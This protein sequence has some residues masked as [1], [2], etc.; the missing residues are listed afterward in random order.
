MI[1]KK[2]YYIIAKNDDCSQK[3]E[4]EMHTT[5]SLNG[6][7]L[8]QESPDLVVTIGGDGTFLHA[9]HSYLDKLESIKVV[10]IHTGT[11]GFF[12]N[13]HDHELDVFFDDLFNQRMKIHPIPVLQ[14]AV[15]QRDES[16]V[17]EAI[18]E[19]RVENVTRTQTLDI[20][21]NGE[22]FESYRG[23]GMCISTQAGSTAYNRSLGG[24]VL[25]D[26]LDFLQLTEITGIHHSAFRSLG[27]PL[28]VKKESVIEL[29]SD[30]FDHAILCYD[31][32]H[33]E[34]NCKSFIKVSYSNKYIRLMTRPNYTYFKRL[35]NLF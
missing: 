8:D 3:L 25:Q 13:Y 28:I 11:L 27:S 26:G 15:K 20:K 14:I 5:F 22:E 32:L 2:H 4:A 19:M 17:F 10:G 24:A 33:F 34:L 18:N 9:I 23:T 35:R 30:N 7:I 12:T 29:S 21:I 16:F 6:W 1:D 31:H